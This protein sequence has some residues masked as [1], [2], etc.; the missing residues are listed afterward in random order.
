MNLN[1][2]KYLIGILAVLAI[3]FLGY[4]TGS[5]FATNK[6]VP[7]EQ[8]ENKSFENQRSPNGGVIPNIER[9][10]YEEDSN[11]SKSSISTN[12]NIPEKVLIVL[13]HVREFKE[14]PE[15]YV[16]GRTFQNR[17]GILPKKNEDNQKIEYQEWDVNPKVS[18]KNRGA[19]RLVT[20]D[21]EAYY[22]NDHYKTFIKINE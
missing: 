6:I 17:E 3:F 21:K 12:E 10:I 20:S 7:V 9:D 16:G 14:A 18:G 4:K 15:G 1:S 5:F 19:E 8:V 13:N 2:K 11:S 22:T